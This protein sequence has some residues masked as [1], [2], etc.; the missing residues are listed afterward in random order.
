M[1]RG[2]LKSSSLYFIANAIGKIV[3]FSFWIYLARILSV[4]EMGQ[5][6]LLTVFVTVITFFMSLELTSGFNRFYLEFTDPQK[7][8]EFEFSFISLLILV[9]LVLGSGL[10]FCK[11]LLEKAVLPMGKGLYMILLSMPLA[12]T[13]AG[14]YLCKLRLENRVV[15]VLVVTLIQA[16]VYVG[17]SFLG[18]RFG[19]QKIQAIFLGL[20]FQNVVPIIFY[21]FD[22]QPFRIL[23]D[24]KSLRN[25]LSF[26]VYLFPS[27][28][29]AY[30]SIFAGKY[31]LG[32]IADTASL[33]I[34]EANGKITMFLGMFMD[35]LY[36]ATTPIIYRHYKEE[37]F[38][39]KY[40]LLMI[41]NA[42]GLL[43]L[44]LP[45]GIF[46]RELVH[47][48]AGKQYAA[49]SGIVFPLLVVAI[50][51]FLSKYLAINEHLAK[52]T[53][54]DMIPELGSG[55]L[56]IALSL[57]LIPRF[58]IWGSVIALTITYFFRFIVYLIFAKI[59][60]PS[61]FIGYSNA[62]IYLVG[63]GLFLWLNDR[64]SNF[65]LI[66]KGFIFLTEISILMIIF[67]LISKIS[68]SQVFKM[69]S[70]DS[71]LN[72]LFFCRQRIK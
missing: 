57:I 20:M 59:F 17:V 40:R 47:I 53:Q 45:F 68:M 9:N 51:S 72:R 23:F 8:L 28:F 22:L 69:A 36:Q 37:D 10:F 13:L 32:K 46:S 48:L 2:F 15:M 50:L 62:A 6:S 41:I 56:N 33:G 66:S 70:N 5:W 16:L 31:I 27:L 1:I 4:E 11:P 44:S 29:G 58:G 63:T 25:S 42:F 21:G 67:I 65:N 7:R 43:A 14:T 26:S 38:S 71:T 12:S 35:P 30:M 18:L 34:L 64:I 19:M 60:F 54:Y 55:I 39:A 24:F 61:L 52:K 49:Y 3:T